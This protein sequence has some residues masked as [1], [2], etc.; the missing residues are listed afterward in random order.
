M[1]KKSVYYSEANMKTGKSLTELAAELERQRRASRDFIVSGEAI[2]MSL[3]AE[4]FAMINFGP[5]R[6]PATD[7]AHDQIS[8][9]TGIPAKYY[10]K[11]YAVAPELLVENVNRWISDKQDKRMVRTLDGHVRAL[12]SDRYRALDNA[13]LA[14]VA[15]PVLLNAGC[16]VASCEVTEKR[17]YIKALAPRIQAEVSKGDVVQAG[18]VLS[19]SEVGYGALT[20]EPLIY[21][22]VCTNGMIVPDA[23]LRKTHLGKSSGFEGYVE[24]FRDETRLALDKAL[25]L[26]V[27]DVMNMALSGEGFQVFVEKLARA[28][29]DVVTGDPVQCVEVAKKT[30]GFT[31]DESRVVLRH[32][33]TDGDFSRYGF[34]NA[35][36]RSAQDLANYDRATEFERIGGI[37]IDLPKKDWTVI[38][39]AA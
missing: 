24:Y 21:R 26:Q 17:L 33:L 19:N 4:N 38:A 16:E 23:K 10:K 31:D 30:L 18:I 11:M 35:V 2:R 3:G 9:Y 29:S 37:V 25:W 20:I 13:E 28:Q 32:F 39:N 5:H 8:E 22:L 12:L 34:A 36:T 15:L 1:I 14:E 27:R 6:Y 7:I